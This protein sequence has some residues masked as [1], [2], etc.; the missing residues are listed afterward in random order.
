M[1]DQAEDNP[2]HDSSPTLSHHTYTTPQSIEKHLYLLCAPSSVLSSTDGDLQVASWLPVG[3]AVKYGRC[4][5]LR[6]FALAMVYYT[7]VQYPAWP[8]G[9]EL[10]GYPVIERHRSNASF[11]IRRTCRLSAR[12]PTDVPKV[13]LKWRWKHCFPASSMWTNILESRIVTYQAA[14]N[15]W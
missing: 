10:C 9:N 2:Y 15:W 3:T 1:R 14:L 13:N 11:V 6:L 5:I 8:S 7:R 12:T 4:T